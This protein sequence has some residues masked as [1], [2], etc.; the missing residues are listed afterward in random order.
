M[1]V[2]LLGQEGTNLGAPNVLPLAQPWVGLLGAPPAPP[3]AQTWDGPARSPAP[4]LQLASRLTRAPLG[5]YLWF[6]P[7]WERESLW[8]PLV[9]CLLLFGL[10]TL[11]ACSHSTTMRKPEQPMVTLFPPQGPSV[12]VRV[13]VA[14]TPTQRERGLMYRERLDEDAGMV[15]VFDEDDDHTFWMKNTAIPLDMIF[16]TRDL[17]VAGVVEN[18]EP[19]SLTTR[20]CGRPSRYVLEVNGG[21]ARKHGIVPG[22]RVRFV[23]IL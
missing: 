22:T 20:S 14:R 13:E 8:R 3:A 18:A 23:G 2:G 1:L 4:T 16:I 5:A 11:S 21:F 15:F 12:A 17:V 7:R 6:V 9:V 19:F 10:A